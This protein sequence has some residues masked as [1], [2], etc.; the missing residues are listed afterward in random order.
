VESQRQ[1]FGSILGLNGN[2][3]RKSVGNLGDGDTTGST[4]EILVHPDLLGSIKHLI[5]IQK[6]PQVN[7]KVSKFS[8]NFE[9]YHFWTKERRNHGILR[10]PIGSETSNPIHVW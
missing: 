8:F 3:K 4:K 7:Q 2:S 10:K 1:K 5:L 9:T 6:N